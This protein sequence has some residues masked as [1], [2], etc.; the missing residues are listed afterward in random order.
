[1]K[2]INSTANAGEYPQILLY[3]IEGKREVTNKKNIRKRLVFFIAAVY[4]E[5]Q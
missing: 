1:M 4:Y 3:R 2:V 5:G